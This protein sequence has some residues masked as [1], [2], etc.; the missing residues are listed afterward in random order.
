VV[1]HVLESHFIEQNQEIADLREVNAR[2]AN[3]IAEHAARISDLEDEAF[4][5]ARTE[6]H[7]RDQLIDERTENVFLRN[8]HVY[9]ARS[10]DES[11][12]E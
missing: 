1:N 2:Q 4:D 3:M 7:L 11:E 12:N 9:P 8:E 10:D 6:L 5:A